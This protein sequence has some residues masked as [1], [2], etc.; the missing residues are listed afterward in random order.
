MC[1]S[2]LNDVLNLVNADINDNDICLISQ[3]ILRPYHVTLECGHKF[4][5]SYLYEEIKNQ[6]KYSNKYETQKLKSYQLKCPYCRNT[7]NKILPFYKDKLEIFPKLYG[8][9]YPHT[10][11]MYTSK[12]NYTFKSGKRKGMTCLV[13][14]NENMCNRHKSIV[15]KDRCEALLKT[16]LR[17]NQRCL[18]DA[19]LGK[20]FC[21]IHQK[22]KSD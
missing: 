21:S 3:T 10:Y 18:N 5:Y 2:F 8:V 16:G 14:C 12:C 4:N 19:K 7:Q 20:T 13:P 15:I 17:K 9:N 6:K 11:C 1:D 22:K